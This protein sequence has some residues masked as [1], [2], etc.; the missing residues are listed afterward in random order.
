[1]SRREHKG[2]FDLLEWLNCQPSGVGTFQ[3]FEERSLSLMTSDAGNA[4][5]LHL[6]A[7]VAGN[8]VEQFYGEKLSA[9]IADDAY[10]KLRLLL[11]R[12]IAV[13][14]SELQEYIEFLN[15]VAVA[16]V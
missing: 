6:L 10:N 11:Q 2:L 3:E 16:R 5:V 14:S 8:F 7:D 12:A 9:V 4:A 15:E 1:M 13:S